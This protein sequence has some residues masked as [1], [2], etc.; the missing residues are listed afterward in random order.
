VSP[1]AAAQICAVLPPF[2]TATLVTHEDDPASVAELV[3]V[4]QPTAV[5]IHSE[6]QPG[7]CAALKRQFEAI[8][9]IK[10][11]HVTGMESLDY[12]ARYA[13]VVDA[14][15]LDSRNAATGQVG[16]TGLVHD[17]SLSAAIVQRYKVPVVL[18]GGLTPGNVA[19]AITQVRPF[20]VDVNSGVKAASGPCKNADKM[21][22]FIRRA[23]SVSVE[24]V[25]GSLR[26]SD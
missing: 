6:M 11:Y 5:Q 15:L 10:S 2:V 13:D 19:A 1:Q 26:R 23:K 12:G 4:V 18:A 20:G 9:F 24:P 14:F 25:R 21:R 7:D 22:E 16:G 3:K 8:R 17:W